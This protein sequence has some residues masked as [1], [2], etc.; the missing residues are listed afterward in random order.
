MEVCP[1]PDGGEK[2]A[3]RTKTQSWST[4]ELQLEVFTVNLEARTISVSTLSQN[5][6][7]Q[8]QDSKPGVENSM[9][10]NM[11][12]ATAF[13]S[14]N[15]HNAPC[16][17]CYA[18]TRSTKITIPGR[19][20]CPTSWTREYYGYLMSASK[21]ETHKRTAPICVDANPES[22][23]G[24]AAATYKSMLYFLETTCLGIHCPP[25]A[26]GAEVT[27]VVCTK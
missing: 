5:S 4:K 12:L 9:E 15:H 13:Q 27:C 20:T 11:T 22:M 7:K 17:V 23:D 6:S 24:S 10:Q 19:I 25:Y 14:I 8:Q 1:T 18:G 26:D 16:S 2:H 21:Y 3:L